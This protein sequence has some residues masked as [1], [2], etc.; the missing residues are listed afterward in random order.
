MDDKGVSDQIGTL[1]LVLAVVVLGGGIAVVVTA[2]LSEPAVTG[3]SLTL[4]SVGEGDTTVRILMRNGEPV[5]LDSIRV[6]LQRNDSTAVEVPRSSWTTQEASVLRAGQRLN[7]TFAPA[8]GAGETLRLR[9]YHTEANVL[10]AELV[11]QTPGA[12]STAT[13]ATLTAAFTPSAVPADGAATSLLAVRVSHPHGALTIAAVMMDLRNI[14][15]RAGT[16]NESV[17]LRDDGYGGDELGGDG[18]WSALLRLSSEVPAG[19]YIVT[20]DAIDVLGRPAGTTTASITVASG[21]TA[22]TGTSF[23]VPTSQNVTRM[24]LQNFTTDALFPARLDGDYVMTRV[25]D[26]SKRA[27]SMEVLLEDVGGTAYATQ[28]RAWNDLNETVYKPRNASRIPLASL[29]MDLMDP[30][31]SLQWVVDTGSAHP[32]ALYAASRVGTGAHLS[33]FRLGDFN[34]NRGTDTGLFTVDVVIE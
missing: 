1:L 12:S 10:L 27:W 32:T 15:M 19:T 22:S 29:D 9:I 4:G 24:R 8:A 34:S 3:A 30:V 7:L 20:V 14:S 23:A 18:I 26:F 17:E 25:V 5:P 28:M 13:E 11:Q 21:Q 2:S 16:P 6:T 33:V 31:A